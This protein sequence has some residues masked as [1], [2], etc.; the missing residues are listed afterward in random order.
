MTSFDSIDPARLAQIS[1]GDRSTDALCTFGARLKSV[2]RQWTGTAAPTAGAEAAAT[3]A[4]ADR[5][6]A[7][8]LQP[9]AL[10]SI[11]SLKL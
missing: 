8:L 11:P 1:G 2:A 5:C 4:D 3:A 6:K 7:S 10:P 9:L